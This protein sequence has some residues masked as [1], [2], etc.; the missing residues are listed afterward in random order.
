MP[1]FG[2]EM[3]Y[4]Y[5]TSR[6]ENIQ[7]ILHQLGLIGTVFLIQLKDRLEAASCGIPWLI[8]AHGVSQY[9]PIDDSVVP[10]HSIPLPIRNFTDTKSTVE[11]VVCVHGLGFD[12]FAD[13]TLDLS[14]NVVVAGCVVSF[15]S[16]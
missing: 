13:I 1:N 2:I 4:T 5:K 6:R 3:R 15:F 12:L 10:D 11:L 14:K 8:P 7:P 16:I 9:I